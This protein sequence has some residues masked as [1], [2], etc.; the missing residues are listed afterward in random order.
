M[1]ETF[2]AGIMFVWAMALTA[3]SCEAQGELETVLLSCL[4]LGADVVV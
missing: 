2:V 1:M 4:M 3:Q